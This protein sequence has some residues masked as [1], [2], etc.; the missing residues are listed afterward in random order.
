MIKQI[1]SV[2][3]STNHYRVISKLNIKG[4]P[5]PITYRRN[6]RINGNHIGETTIKRRNEEVNEEKSTILPHSNDHL[7]DTSNNIV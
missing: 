5:I 3:L 2:R 7:M 6:T 4:L 1:K